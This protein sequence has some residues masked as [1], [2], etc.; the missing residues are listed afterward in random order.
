MPMHPASPARAMLAC[1]AAALFTVS[2][3]TA[4]VPPPPQERAEELPAV[5]EVSSWTVTPAEGYE[6]EFGFVTLDFAPPGRADSS[7]VPGGAPPGRAETADAPGGRLTVHL[8]RRSMAHADSAW[9]AIRVREGGDVLLD[10]AGKEG[11][12]N[13][14]GPDGNW[15]NDVIIDLSAPFSRDRGTGC[16]AAAGRRRARR[17]RPCLPG[18]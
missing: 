16:R 7:D 11:I 12:P 17:G 6:D 5:K 4:P 18:C 15:W 14:K 3:A 13:V 1:C 8:G 10:F 9:Y 2:C